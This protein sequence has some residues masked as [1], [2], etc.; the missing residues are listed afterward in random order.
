MKSILFFLLGLQLSVPQHENVTKLIDALSA[1]QYD[2]VECLFTPDGYGDFLSICDSYYRFEV[3]ETPEF[4]VHSFGDRM[5]VRSVPIIFYPDRD[6][7]QRFESD[8]VFLLNSKGLIESVTYALDTEIVNAVQS[9]ENWPSESQ[10]AVIN[11]M[12]EYMTAYA[13]KEIDSI[14]GA[15]DQCIFL[16]GQRSEFQDFI[17]GFI[18]SSLMADFINVSLADVNVTKYPHGG[19]VYGMQFKLNYFTSNYNDSGYQFILIDVNNP[20]AVQICASFWQNEPDPETGLFDM[21]YL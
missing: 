5:M 13:I 15:I 21:S 17:Q 18:K 2:N 6:T 14:T 12:E 16:P 1:Q 19:E 3:M 4:S 11:F 8:L 20:S 7:T 10:L 9:H